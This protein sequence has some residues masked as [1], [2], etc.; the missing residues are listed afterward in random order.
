MRRD[1][2]DIR[3]HGPADASETVF[4]LPGGLCTAAFYD[5]LAREPAL[6][7]TRLLAA[8]LPGFGGTQPGEELTIEGWARDA[9]A[10]AAEVGA[11]VVVGHSIGANV[12]LEMGALGV[13]SAPL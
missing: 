6:Q 1:Q 10:L 13:T 2:W 9:G 7:R 11:D 5:A 12:V 4:L 3:E 8:T